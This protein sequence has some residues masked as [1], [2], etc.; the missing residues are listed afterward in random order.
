MNLNCNLDNSSFDAVSKT[1]SALRFPLAVM[2]I[3]LHCGINDM[4]YSAIGLTDL[5]GN[6]PIYCVV[7]WMLGHFVSNAAVPVFFI[8]S[9]FLLFW[10]VEKYDANVYKNKMKKRVKS[11]LIPYLCWNTIYLL[12]FYLIGHD[13]ISLTSVPDM[14][15]NQVSLGNFL[16]IAYVRPPVD[17]PL[18][19]IRNLFVMTL[20]APIFY[21][22]ISKTKFLVPISLLVISQFTLNS[23]LLSV[24][25][26]SIGI[27]C[28]VHKFDLFKFCR[29]TLPFTTL[30]CLI[31]LIIDIIYFKSSSQHISDH[32]YIFRIMFVIGFV[33]FL[34]EKNKITVNKSLNQSTFVIYAYHSIPSQL[35]IAFLVMHLKTFG[36]IGLFATYALSILLLIMGGAIFKCNHSSELYIA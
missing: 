12:L 16:Y 22:V 2:V 35:L 33:Y 18:W 26:F 7:T 3:V 21:Y 8:M 10:N 11:L 27:S 31:V 17:G 24:L 23:F 19:F 1:I 5:E 4:N 15:A 34:V 29:K 25:W 36:Q 9:S 13:N 14:F 6:F 20:A 28:A 30:M 32:F